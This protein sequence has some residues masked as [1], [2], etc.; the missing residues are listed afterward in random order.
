MAYVVGQQNPG[1]DHLRA[2]VMVCA[3]CVD[4]LLKA[5]TYGYC[6]C[7]MSDA[8]KRRAV[9][10]VDM[11]TTR[12]VYCDDPLYIMVAYMAAR[13]GMSNA[14]VLA[15]IAIDT[16]KDAD[17]GSMKGPKQSKKMPKIQQGSGG[18]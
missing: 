9:Y 11:I 1:L 12:V 13:R 2:K 8:Q 18:R 3:M 10:L 14:A 6:T 7:G 17:H 5:K 4:C 15:M 16:P